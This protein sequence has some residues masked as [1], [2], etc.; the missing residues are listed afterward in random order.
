[1][2]VRA[3]MRVVASFQWGVRREY[4]L[5]LK[6][7]FDAHGIEIPFP[8]LTVHR[9]VA[10]GVDGG[11]ASHPPSDKTDSASAQSNAGTGGA[12]PAS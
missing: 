9:Q 2:K 3:R 7:A 10:A 8:Q 4:L 5:R 11:H 1:V 6:R 12:G